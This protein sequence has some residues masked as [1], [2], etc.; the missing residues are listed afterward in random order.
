MSGKEDP[1]VPA[2]L[3]LK[4]SLDELPSNSSIQARASELVKTS[5]QLKPLADY[6]LGETLV[7]DDLSSI[8]DSTD[9]VGW[10]LVDIA[11][12][13]SGQNLIMKNRKVTDD[14]YIIGRQE[15]LEL[16]TS[17]I[18]TLNNKEEQLITRSKELFKMVSNISPF[19]K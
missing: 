4:V 16:I 10:N 2:R 19:G 3:M 18:D 1:P 8:A 14:R 15:K 7:V 11:G 6:L 9:L 12:A 13:Y 17:E 5:K